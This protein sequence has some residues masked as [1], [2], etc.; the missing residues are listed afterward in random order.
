MSAPALQVPVLIP[1]YEP[2]PELLTTVAALERLGFARIVVVN[3]GSS[4]AAQPVFDQ[5]Q[6]RH[7]R[8]RLLRHAVNLGKGA[9]LKTGFNDI[10]ASFPD[11]PGAVTAD[12]DGQHLPPD[13]LRV[14]EA[15]CA[16]GGRNVIL[17]VRRF[18]RDV[19]L[20]SL[21]GNRISA[22]VMRALVGQK[23]T[24]T[25]TGLRGIPASLIPHLLRLTPNGYEFELD[26]LIAAKHRSV[27]VAEIPIET[28]YL[29]E[30]RSSHFNPLWDSMRIY[31]VFLRFALASLI[32][33]VIDNTVFIA[34]HGAWGNIL[35]PQLAAR[36][37][38]LLFNYAAARRAVFQ[39]RDRHR[40]TLPRFLLLA[41]AHIS[42]S[43]G[44][45]TYLHLF[46]GLKV[47]QAKLAVEATL[48]LA[49]FAIQRDFV[50]TKK[51]QPA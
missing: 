38:A 31:F 24:D 12:A 20:R 49:N 11:A 5:L 39:S 6:A 13:I 2:P 37:A 40:D 41:A 1:A 15:L 7:P 36:A 34:L 22:A 48:F 17:G 23:L 29:N 27:P 51:R 50:F 42:L 32:T 18:D 25:Q 10:L 45:I 28:V 43:Y 35:G 19:P 46:T 47:I 26:V 9:A 21:L 16:C 8:V 30:N 3:D 44:M 33:A 4:P 14:S